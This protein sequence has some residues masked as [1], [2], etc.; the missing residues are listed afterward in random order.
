MEERIYLDFN[1]STPLAPEV[2]SAIRPFLTDHFGNPSSPHWAGSPARAALEHA[3]SQVAALV[4]AH[5][6]EIVF[7]SGGTEANNHALQGVFFA[8]REQRDHIITSSV[9]HPAIQ[10]P[11]QWLERFGARVTVLPVDSKGRVDPE[12][13]QRAIT[14][15]TLLVT[16]MHA[17][18]EV[19]TVQPIAEI[20]AVAHAASVLVHTD[21]AQSV[22]KISTRV[23]ELGVDLLSIAGHKLYAPKGVGALYIR[24]G[25]KVESFLR[26][27][28]H[29]QGRRAGTENVLL[30]VAL[31]TACEVAEGWI[32]MP[33]VRA[34]RDRF[35]QEL[36]V[37]YGDDVSVNG[38][39]ASRL[40]NTANVNFV[41]RV[42]ASIL[43]RLHGVA[44]S[45]G[46]ACHAGS[47][48]LSPVLCAMGVR[49][50]EGMGA[51]RFSL[52]RTTTW[53]E[54]AK[55]LSMLREARLE[56]RPRG[57]QA[58][59]ERVYAN[60]P[61]DELS[62]YEARPHASLTMI[63]RTGVGREAR[64]LDVGGGASRLVDALLDEG[65]RRISV[66]DIA[67]AALAV[68]KQRLGDR[69]ASIT[70]IAAD[71]TEWVPEDT[72]DVWHDRAAFHFLTQPEQRDGYRKALR[73]ALRPGGH[74]ILGT[75]APD[76]PERC[77]GLPIVRYEP[78]AL[79]AEL[80]PG[81]RLVE[82]HHEEHVTPAGRVQRFQFSRFVRE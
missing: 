72:Y 78:E 42:G 1:A 19:G 62:W 57:R 49:P 6:D 8:N 28:D 58:H 43:E 52:G 10:K 82:S 70:W 34:L 18:N 4:G 22:G 39:G 55:V 61:E 73:A 33:E 50:E 11:L 48:E 24:R 59:W 27:A 81:F 74:A 13:V 25:T 71:A 75:F 36:K 12:A 65:F 29:E 47:V 80:G 46:S 40:P 32:G 37:L 2:V 54:L 77:S 60:K 14:P 21:A 17:N 7:S 5:P 79:A 66:L 38:E 20:A 9:E 31:G 53:E 68:A 26:G 69:G 30:D 41:G 51:V 44:A 76:G 15:R 23:D 3:R 64:I 63:A 67:E 35:E 16:V 45:T 56:S